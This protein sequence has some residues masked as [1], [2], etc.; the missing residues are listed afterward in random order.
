VLAVMNAQVHN[1]ALQGVDAL[2]KSL[3]IVRAL[4]M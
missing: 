2:P 3:V 4:Q 1:D